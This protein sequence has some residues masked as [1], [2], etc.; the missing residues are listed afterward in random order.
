MS[1][2]KVK[3]TLGYLKIQKSISLVIFVI[4]DTDFS[5]KHI[6]I[7]IAFNLITFLARFYVV[8]TF[9]RSFI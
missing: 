3:N 5:Y 1:Y 7:F 4:I 6:S 8:R 2:I 9:P